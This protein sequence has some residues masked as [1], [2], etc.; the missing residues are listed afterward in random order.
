MS[1]IAGLR[2]RVEAATGADREID[3]LLFAELIDNRDVRTNENNMFLGRNRKPP[4]DECVLGYIDP[5]KH[6]RNFY[7][8][9]NDIPLLTASLD[10]SL[11][12]VEKVKP[13]ALHAASFGFMYLGHF[14]AWCQLTGPSHELAS[15]LIDYGFAQIRDGDRDALPRAVIVS[16][17]ASME[18]PD[19]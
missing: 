9:R 16:L 17:L 6:A 5:G 12:L 15:D 11:A 13:L 19:A 14:G 4:H 10:A 2:K 7:T 3:V 1:D 8:A 18:A